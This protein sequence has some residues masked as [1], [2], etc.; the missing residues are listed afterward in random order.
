MIYQ[1][2]RFAP[3]ATCCSYLISKSNVMD[4]IS[5]TLSKHTQ[6]ERDRYVW[7]LKVKVRN[8]KPFR[9]QKDFTLM[10]IQSFLRLIKF[11]VNHERKIW[12]FCLIFLTRPIHIWHILYKEH[13]VAH[14]LVLYLRVVKHTSMHIY[15][16]CLGFIIHIRY[17]Y[18]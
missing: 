17:M 1:M 10:W 8:M 13:T 16:K 9:I 5:V 3:I 7:Y 14:K 18:Y 12:D 4:N 2:S 6:Q 11:H 15:Q